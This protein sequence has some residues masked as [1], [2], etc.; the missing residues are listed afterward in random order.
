MHAA[1]CTGTSDSKQY[2]GLYDSIPV[3]SLRE[4]PLDYASERLFWDADFQQELLGGMAQLGK[5]VEAALGGHPQ[6][7]SRC[8]CTTMFRSEELGISGVASHQHSA[9]SGTQTSSKSCLGAWLS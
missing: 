4:R 2:A 5:D 8:W 9:C 7:C 3:I 1:H 6:A